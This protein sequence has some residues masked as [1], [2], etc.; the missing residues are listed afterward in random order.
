[1]SRKRWGLIAVLLTALVFAFSASP[2]LGGVPDDPGLGHA[3]NVANEHAKGLLLSPLVV[4]VGVGRTAGGQ[5]AVVV[6]T[7]S[8]GANIPATL[9]GVPVVV[10][11]TGKIFALCHRGGNDPKGCGGAAAGI[12]VDPT[13][14][15][16][17][18]EAGG[19]DTF[20]VVLDTLPSANVDSLVTRPV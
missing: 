19:Q 9:D 13:S 12:T 5:A 11:V 1:M 17:T 2:V 8:A 10:A 20:T 14:G 16:V 6:L 7:E 18:T 15:L 3:K 4:G